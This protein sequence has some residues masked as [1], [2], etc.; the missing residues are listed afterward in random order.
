MRAVVDLPAPAGPSI[1]TTRRPGCGGEESIEAGGVIA[2]HPSMAIARRAAIR[3][4]VIRSPRVS[5]LAFGPLRIVRGRR[6]F[7]VLALAALP[8]LAACHRGQPLIGE[9]APAEAVV[10][11]VGAVPITA[12]GGEARG[13]GPRGGGR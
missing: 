5:A 1:A 11:H 3:A 4:V 12:R 13:G 6:A 9:A 8:A 10:A 2:E 7:G